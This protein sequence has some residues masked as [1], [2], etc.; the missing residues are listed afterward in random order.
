VALFVESLDI[1]KSAVLVP[2]G[3]T[4]KNE[5]IIILFER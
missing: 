5:Q 2:K 4:S 1:F 3:L